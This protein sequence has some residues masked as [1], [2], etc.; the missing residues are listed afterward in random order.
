MELVVQLQQ[1]WTRLE[2]L[3]EL[4]RGP[5]ESHRLALLLPGPVR[6]SQLGFIIVAQSLGLGQIL[7]CD[8]QVS[9]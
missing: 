5:E 7:I 2:L 1:R 4:L 3:L 9:L 8:L 6:R